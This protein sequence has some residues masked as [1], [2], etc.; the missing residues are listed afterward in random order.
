MGLNVTSPYFLQQKMAVRVKGNLMFHE[1]V[2]DQET[3]WTPYSN[4]SV[5]LAGTSGIMHGFLRLYGEGGIIGLFPNSDFSSEDFVFG[6]YGLFGFEFYMN[7][8]SNYFIELGGIGTGAN[9]DKLPAKPIYSNG[10]L[11]NFGY[12]INFK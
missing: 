3:V 11:L 4:A 6:G 12:R 9:A 10:L 2:Q 5:G 7:R 1:H 8:H